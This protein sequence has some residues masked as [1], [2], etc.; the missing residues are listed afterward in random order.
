MPLPKL[1]LKA[2]L[3]LMIPRLAKEANQLKDIEARSRWMKLRKIA[4]SV[5]STD[6]ACANAGVSTD[7]F[8][9]WGNKL[10]KS[11]RL[12]GLFTKS[13]KP[14]RSP[15]KT[16]PRIEKQVLK[17]RRVEPYLGPERI[18]D[19]A[20]KLF[21][22]TVAPST[23]FA[24]LRRAKVVGKKIAEKLT[25]KHT[26]RYRRMLPGYLQMDFKYVPYLIENK[27]YYQLSCVDH[28]SSW[29][30]IRCF[31]HKDLDSVLLFLNELKEVC[32]FAIM[33]IQT[34]NDTAFTDKFS[35]R[36]GVT[37]E[38]KMDLWC[39]QQDIVHRLIPVGV[40][41]L[42]GKVENTHKQDDREF[43]AMNYFSTYESIALSTKGYSDRWNTQRA[44]KALGWLTPAQTIE[45][46][47]VKVIAM[48]MFI[49]E[50]GH[51]SVYKLNQQGDAMM[52]VPKPQKQVQ[53]KNKT[54][55]VSAV[56]KYLSYLEWADQN[57]LKCLI[58]GNP[59]ISPNFS[60]FGLSVF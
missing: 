46:A 45:Q 3:R 24:I 22:L 30:L 36:M 7:W 57:K 32:P 51:T 58:L 41:E 60:S 48:M 18:S 56:D 17:I 10:I 47:Y 5:K 23:I 50:E 35:S 27:Q 55:K 6:H 25:K 12:V 15:N 14:H 19:T 49:K 43:F 16:K 40:K 53:K 21:N 39:A 9:K 38:H 11:R 59:T 1:K 34:D 44:T 52:T 28:H 4:L 31:R 13:R 8:R 26:K 37:G 42:N 33:E 2:E 29:R 54:R 20:E